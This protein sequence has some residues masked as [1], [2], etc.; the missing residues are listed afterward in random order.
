MNGVRMLFVTYLAVIGLAGLLRPA[1]AARAVNGMRRFLRDNGLGLTFGGLFLGSL[2]GQAFAGLAQFNE[3]QVA[4]G[5]E[6]VP[7]LR[8]LT[9]SSFCGR[10][11]GELAV[12]VPAVFP[13]R[14]RDGVAGP[15][16]LSGVQGA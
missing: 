9:S 11:G 12:G 13:L 8:Y 4:E 2:I 16:R 7:L 3:Q 10:R 6:P 14:L 5:S 15:A 1:R